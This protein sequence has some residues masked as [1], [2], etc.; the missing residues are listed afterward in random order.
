MVL[1]C[2]HNHENSILDTVYHSAKLSWIAI[3]YFYCLNLFLTTS[4]SESGGT[5]CQRPSVNRV[6]SEGGGA[7][8]TKDKSVFPGDSP[9]AETTSLSGKTGKHKLEAH[10]NPQK[11][12]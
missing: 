1:T 6:Q 5:I 11:T 12:H 10:R 8:M 7:L 3:Y 9:P 4:L 2:R